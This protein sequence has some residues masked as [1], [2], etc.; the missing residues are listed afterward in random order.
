MLIV[1]IGSAFIALGLLFTGSMIVFGGSLL[2]LIDGTLA[3]KTGKNSSF[4]A[5]LDSVVDRIEESS[6]L[7]AVFLFSVFNN[8]QLT[9]IR[10]ELIS[11]MVFLALIVSLLVSY[12]RARSE[13][14]GVECKEGIMTRPER[15]V[16]LTIGIAI[17]Q[18]SSLAL[19]L[20]LATIIVLGFF[21]IIQ[22][23]LSTYDKLQN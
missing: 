19:L 15:V 7:F 10:C 2:D 12:M 11:V 17:F 8:C 6:V 9:G 5:L 21:T 1:L 13:S 4:G 14:L 16:L 18:W 3:R 22:R 23:L 20:I